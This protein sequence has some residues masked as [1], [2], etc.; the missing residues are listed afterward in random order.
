[1]KDAAPADRASFIGEHFPGLGLVVR[2]GRGGFGEVWRVDDGSRHIVLKLL[3]PD[4]PRR[5]WQ[6]EVDAHRVVHSARIPGMIDAGAVVHDGRV[7]RWITQELVDGPNVR[8]MMREESW[9]SASDLARFARAVLQAVRDVHA[10]GLIFRDVS[11]GNIVL[12]G[13]RWDRPMLVDLGLVVPIDAPP[14]VRSRRAGTRAY[15]APEQLGRDPVTPATDLFGVGVVCF[16]LAAQGGHPFLAAGERIGVGEA[17][18]RI[19]AGPRPLPAE[20]QMNERWLRRLL[21]FDP[22]DRLAGGLPPE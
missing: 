13:G 18:E 7:T 21:A 22:V 16:K 1:M 15:K 17:Q 20:H 3:Q 6:R 12:V 14:A 10:A 11:P 2:L 8:V 9:P 5:R 19:A 4:A